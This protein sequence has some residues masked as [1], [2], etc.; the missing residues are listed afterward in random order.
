M[1]DEWLHPSKFDHFAVSMTFT[2]APIRVLDDFKVKNPEIKGVL[3]MFSAGLAKEFLYDNQP[4]YKDLA[5]N[6][7]GCVAG[8]YLNRLY[9]NIE[10]SRQRKRVAGFLPF[11]ARPE[12]NRRRHRRTQKD[13]PI[14]DSRTPLK[15]FYRQNLKIPIKPNCEEKHK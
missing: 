14:K 4:S 5:F 3:I 15:D 7:A 6:A 12:K 9:N 13:N 11:Y 2:P 8:Y 10:K 1:Q